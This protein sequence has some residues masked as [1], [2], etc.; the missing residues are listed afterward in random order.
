[1]FEVK[2]HKPIYKD[3]H[4]IVDNRF[5]LFNDGDNDVM[6]TGTNKYGNRLLCSI[7]FEDDDAGF[8]RYIHSLVS[9]KQYSDFINK[10]I[11]FRK[12]LDMNE[13]VFL[14]DVDYSMNEI[15]HNLT[16]IDEI[17]KEFIPLENSFCPEFIFD[18]SFSYSVSLIGGLADLH[19]AEAQELSEVST[20]FSDFL[21]SS[22]EF[23]SDLDV[24]KGIYV[25]ALKA[26]SFEINYKIELEESDQ[27]DLIGK[28]TQNVNDFLSN[29][30][31]YFFNS[32]PKEDKDVFQKEVVQSD[33]FKILEKQ[34]EKIYE[35]NYVLPP[36]GVEQKLIDLINYSAKQI[37]NI[38]YNKSFKELKFQE[39]TSQ[40]SKVPYGVI[41]EEF[42][43]TIKDKMFNLEPPKLEMHVQKDEF[44]KEYTFRVYKFS[45]E[46]GKGSAYFTNENGE[47]SKIIIHATGKNDYKHTKFTKSMDEGRPYTFKGIGK[48]ENGIL[49]K[50]TCDLS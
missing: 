10:N 2:K 5:V 11:S 16:Y 3:F 24:K 49:K 40:G 32:L 22:T 36:A 1:M 7:M 33:E 42:I 35:D 17:P 45:S 6:F 29:Y 20:H 21:N 37:E 26:G 19:K 48:F 38:E 4:K 13:T 27:I 43:P 47:T 31:K 18:K 44:P 46:S 14:V 41:G 39:N 9:E 15:D 50:V 28:S 30:F 23:L 34:L 25:E 12:I 8:L